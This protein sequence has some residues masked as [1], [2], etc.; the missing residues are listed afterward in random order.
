ML[1]SKQRLLILHQEFKIDTSHI[2]FIDP[3]LNGYHYSDTSF[4]FPFEKLTDGELYFSLLVF[5]YM[6]HLSTRYTSIF[7]LEKRNI[8]ANIL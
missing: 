4:K 5:S 6:S 1:Y 3:T 7:L 2:F 8:N